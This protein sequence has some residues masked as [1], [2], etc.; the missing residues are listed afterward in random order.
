MQI[1]VQVSDNSEL[2][3]NRAGLARPPRR[4]AVRLEDRDVTQLITEIVV[5]VDRL[6]I[7]LKSDHGNEASD[8]SENQ[9]LSIPQNA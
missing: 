1:A 7:R 8:A 6:I 4:N 3:T 9:S 5:H 2:P